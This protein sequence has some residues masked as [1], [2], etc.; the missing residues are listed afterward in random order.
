ME[1]GQ[2][3]PWSM[4]QNSNNIMHQLGLNDPDTQYEL[5]LIDIT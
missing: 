2:S 5:H 3:E 1:E 4:D